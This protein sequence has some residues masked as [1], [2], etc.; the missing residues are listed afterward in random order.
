MMPRCGV[1]CRL[2]TVALLQHDEAG[3]V[4]HWFTA[5]VPRSRRAPTLACRS[6]R[7][8]VTLE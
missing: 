4:L 8:M 6:G 1:C 7:L 3:A 2:Q 5:E